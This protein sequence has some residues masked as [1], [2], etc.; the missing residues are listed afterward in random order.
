MMSL[1]HQS[2]RTLGATRVVPSYLLRL[3]CSSTGSLLRA[4][5]STTSTTFVHRHD[6]TDLR[7]LYFCTAS[8]L[9]FVMLHSRAPLSCV[10]VIL[11]C[12]APLSCSTVMLR[13]HA[14]LCRVEKT[15]FELRGRR[16]VLIYSF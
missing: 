15:A 12:H 6:H 2:E 1:R 7:N 8:I 5:S 13:S 14:A 9:V 3:A 16:V 11:R 4:R 10:T